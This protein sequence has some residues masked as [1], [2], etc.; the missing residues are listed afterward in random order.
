MSS[1][2]PTATV[3][4][5]ALSH[6]PVSLFGSV[7]GLT[8]LSL[9]W[10]RAQSQFNL[11]TE[12]SAAIGIAAIA[13]FLALAVAYAIKMATHFE[14]VRNEFAHPVSGNFFGTFIISLLLLP[15][16]LTSYNMALAKVVWG[17][18]TAAMIAFAWLILNRWMSNKQQIQHASPAWLIPVVGMLDVPL[19]Q[20]AL[21]LDSYHSLILFTFS[22][23]MFFAIPLFTLVFSRLVFSEPLPDAMKPSLLILLAPF[24]VGYSAY[25]ETMGQTDAFADVLFCLMLFMLSVLLGLLA[26]LNKGCPFRHTWW[27]VGFPLAASSNAALR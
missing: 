21:G 14:V 18:G 5:S 7:M 1:I 3:T 8:G 27:A 16:V 24:S 23:G 4:E 11:P 13:V 26:K 15:M 2:E 12:I 10:H 19:A 25:V 20:T 9:A 22:V 17:V 6:L